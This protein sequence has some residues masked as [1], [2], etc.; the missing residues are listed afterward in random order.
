MRENGFRGLLLVKTVLQKV[1]TV[2]GA[3]SPPNRVHPK[4]DT[5]I[6]AMVG[7]LCDQ[8]STF[9]EIALVHSDWIWTWR[10]QRDEEGLA[11]FLEELAP[12][13][14]DWAQIVGAVD[15]TYARD[16]ATNMQARAWLERPTLLAES[17]EKIRVVRL[18][19]N[20]GPATPLSPP[21]ARLACVFS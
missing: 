8:T 2:N 1:E 13:V 6:Q 21:R 4:M 16:W 9:A 12:L 20:P 17:R 14:A 18:D 5:I 11:T 3:P 15:A 10:L 7:L 19:S